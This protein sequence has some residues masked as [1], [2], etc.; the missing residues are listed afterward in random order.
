MYCIEVYTD[1][2]QKWMNGYDFTRKQSPFGY[3]YMCRAE[4]SE[5]RKI[6][7]KAAGH[8]IRTRLYDERW[9]RSSDYRERYLKSTHGPY[10][11][12]YCGKFLKKEYMVIDHIIP[13][14]RTKKSTYTRLLLSLRGIRTVNDVRNLTASC[15]KCNKKKS[16]KT[17]IWLV[18]AFFGKFPWYFT[19]RKLFPFVLLAAIVVFI[20]YMQGIIS[21]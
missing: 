13:V 4:L 18:K 12:R 9:G 3:Y 11:C 20:L 7:R 10:R 5:C 8:R 19:V 17:G 6:R 1:K 15:R 21:F 14:A 2:Y 16:D